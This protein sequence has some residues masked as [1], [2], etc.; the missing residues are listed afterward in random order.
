MK[1]G[2]KKT[3]SKNGH[4]T[5]GTG[6]REKPKLNKPISKMTDQELLENFEPHEILQMALERRRKNI[7]KGLTLE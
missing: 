7:A 1:N 6:T 4:S 3:T 5:N 2:N